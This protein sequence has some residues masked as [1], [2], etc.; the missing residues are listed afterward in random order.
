M[1][2]APPNSVHED[3]AAN[4]AANPAEVKLTPAAFLRWAALYLK[5]HGWIQGVMFADPHQLAPASCTHGAIRMAVCGSTTAS[6]T[7]VQAA[8]VNRTTRVL[9]GYVD[10]LYFVWGI[11]ATGNEVDADQIVG[12][13][14]DETGR[15]LDEVIAT[16]H[17]AAN[18]WDTC[19]LDA[20]SNARRGIDT[21]G[22]R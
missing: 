9:A 7:P 10:T 2:V 17:E 15:T 1:T 22:P 14:N 16:L 12:D 11:D 13:W 4:P 3:Q 19:H 8:Q 5:R 20:N 6:L 18:E 21:G